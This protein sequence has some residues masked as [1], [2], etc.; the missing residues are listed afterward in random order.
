MGL[1]NGALFQ[2]IPQRFRNEI[3]VA[4]GIVG[5]TGGVGGFFLPLLLGL[6]KDLTGSYG[7]GLLLFALAALTAV[8]ALRALQAGWQATL[9]GEQI[10]GPAR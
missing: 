4:T 3:G 8:V 10:A 7:A 6:M 1:G 9:V 2:V 5:A